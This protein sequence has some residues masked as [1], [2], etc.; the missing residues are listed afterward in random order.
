MRCGVRIMRLL[1]FAV[2]RSEKSEKEVHPY[3]MV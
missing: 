1:P 2:T 3:E